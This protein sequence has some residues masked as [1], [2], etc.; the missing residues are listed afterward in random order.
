M[1]NSRLQ[2]LYSER[3]AKRRDL[4]RSRSI[5]GDRFSLSNT[6]LALK[7]YSSTSLFDPELTERMIEGDV[8]YVLE[9]AIQSNHA[10]VF[11]KKHYSDLDELIKIGQ[12]FLETTETAVYQSGSFSYYSKMPKIRSFDDIIKYLEKTR[13]SFN[14]FI[15][16]LDD[17]LG[18][19]VIIGSRDERT[20]N[21][22]L[23]LRRLAQETEIYINDLLTELIHLVSMRKIA[24]DAEVSK[25]AMP[26]LTLAS[27]IVTI[28]VIVLVTPVLGFEGSLVASALSYLGLLNF[29]NLRNIALVNKTA[30]AYQLRIAEAQ[31]ER[32]TPE[33]LTTDRCFEELTKAFGLIRKTGHEMYLDIVQ[34][35]PDLTQFL[36]LQ[37]DRL[38]A[39]I[40]ELSHLRRLARCVDEIL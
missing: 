19:Y 21:K 13:T 35:R 36:A 14:T 26:L 22:A 7:R 16:E 12:E 5:T 4:A 27:M 37:Q 32:L 11:N 18:K 38:E 33:D 6:S 39:L 10:R 2:K 24:M 30:V 20:A 31:R 28:G 15:N 1:K 9:E 40:E 29:I 3:E 17:R 23:D 25:N 34:N 8:E